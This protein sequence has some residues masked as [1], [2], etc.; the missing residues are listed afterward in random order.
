MDTGSVDYFNLNIAADFDGLLNYQ[1]YV[2]ATGEFDGEEDLYVIEEGNFNVP[3]FYGR[4][5]R[6]TA[7]VQGRSLNRF[8]IETN[9]VKSITRLPNVNTAS[10]AGSVGNRQLALP[11][12]VSQIYDINIEPQAATAYAVNLYVSD[13]ATSQI[14]IPVIRSKNSTTPTIGLFGIDNDAR[15]G[16]VDITITSLARMVMTGGNLIVVE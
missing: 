4:Y 7:T 3:A 14:L 6:V 16:I 10:L 9:R 8:T 2:S 12:A 11:K 5:V 13:T 1:V 15:D